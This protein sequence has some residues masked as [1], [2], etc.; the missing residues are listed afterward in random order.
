MKSLGGYYSRFA[1][2]PHGKGGFVFKENPSHLF[3]ET[4]E[5]ETNVNVE[6]YN[7]SGE[8]QLRKTDKDGVQPQRSNRAV[9]E[10]K[11]NSERG[12]GRVDRSNS[13][14]Q[15]EIRQGLIRNVF[16]GTPYNF[17]SHE[18]SYVDWGIHFGNEE[19][20][21][22]RLSNGQGN[23]LQRD[24]QL[25]NPL[26]T[27]D[28]FGERTPEQYVT[29]LVEKS[30]LSE[31]EK[32]VLKTAFN[33]FLK[34]DIER[35]ARTSLIGKLFGG[36]YQIKTKVSQEGVLVSLAIVDDTSNT[37]E[38]PLTELIDKNKL[39]DIL[40]F[41]ETAE[42]LKTEQLSDTVNK[43]LNEYLSKAV[44][45]F[46][47]QY[48][49][50]REIENILKSFGYDGFAYHNE[51][52]GEGWSYAVFDNEQILNSETHTQNAQ[53]TSNSNKADFKLEET[54][55]KMQEV[56]ARFGLT[57]DEA[58]S[59]VEYKTAEAYKIN[60]KLRENEEL[61]TDYQKDIVKSLDSALEKLP[62]HKGTIYR[63]VSF[64]DLFD[65]EEEYN[66]FLDTHE[67]GSFVAYKAYTSASSKSDGHPMPDNTKYGITLEIEGEN[68]RDI[69]GFGNNFEKEVVCPRGIGFVVTNVTTDSKGRP[70][71]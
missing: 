6:G 59:V 33:N 40:G 39:I 21:K 18:K 9:E 44:L 23:I 17:T 1:E 51:N 47:T 8:T 3:G 29:E 60:A 57:E 28:I 10:N 4:Q 66:S 2:T 27:Q 55:K 63:T 52:E 62:K 68:G 36:N 12:D 69:D 67:V 43:S 26:I 64:D 24:L 34:S 65:A 19:Q 61:L 37:N 16:H 30:E 32:E 25:K 15:G 50:L 56:M 48:L 70:Y 58:N 53:N 14:E 13:E 45:P 22:T 35:E 42:I 20:A 54:E 31:S 7:S 38:I 71:I 11:G 41:E 5:V 46:E 49:K